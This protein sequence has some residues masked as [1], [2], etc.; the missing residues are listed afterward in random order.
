MSLSRESVDNIMS[1][2]SNSSNNDDAP[3]SLDFPKCAL[4]G[5]R[6]QQRCSR[7]QQ[8]F[9]CSREHQV[10]HWE[11][12]KETCGVDKQ[13]GN[14]S[15]NNDASNQELCTRCLQPARPGSVCCVP[16][17]VHLR[18]DRGS[19]LG[20]S[21]AVEQE[22]HC[23]ACECPYTLKMLPGGEL[24][25]VT[26]GPEWCFE[27]PHTTQPLQDDNQ[28]RVYKDVVSM[29]PSSDFRTD[30]LRL[31]DINKIRVL[32]LG[33]NSSRSRSTESRSYQRFTLDME[34]PQL[35]ELKLVNVQCDALSLNCDLTPKLKKLELENMPSKAKVSVEA[36]LLEYCS[37]QHY[38]PTHDDGEWLLEMLQNTP[39]LE[40]F[41]SY[42]LRVPE[43]AFYGNALTK[44]DLHR[45]ECLTSLTIYAPTL[46]ELNLQACYALE[47][48]K[49]LRNYQNYR[50]LLPDTHQKDT[51]IRVN[52]VN[53]VLGRKAQCALQNS[54]RVIP[55]EESQQEAGMPPQQ[56]IF[57]HMR[58]MGF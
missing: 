37:I 22:Y 48:I 29:T 54:R 9:Y 50:E 38:H 53:A 19:V 58:Q 13:N 16:H 45:A 31:H 28:R 2:I 33:N 41:E 56:A 24:F 10:Q 52:T 35:Q 8:V 57:A 11:T 17:P 49:F 7:C 6:A 5:D 46:V 21:G 55:T 36:P 25:R 40:T 51:I 1:A 34:L 14:N 18:Q 42:K 26:K 43:I 39:K 12:H 4:C 30:L 15:N 27:G 44:I 20:P 47:E 3:P 23:L 32:V